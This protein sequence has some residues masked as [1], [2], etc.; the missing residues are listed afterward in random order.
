MYFKYKMLKYLTYAEPVLKKTKSYSYNSKVLVKTK[1]RMAPKIRKVN[2][3]VTD[4]ASLCGMDHYGNRNK[5]LCRIWKQL[6][7]G[8]YKE[9][10]EIIRQKGLSCALDSN[11][12]KIKIMEQRTGTSVNVSS[13]ILSINQKKEKDSGALVKNQSTVSNDINNCDKLTKQEKEKMISLMN[14]ATNVVF[15]CRNEGRGIDAFTRIT[16]KTIQDKQTKLVYEFATTKMTNGEIIQWNITGKYDGLTTDNE[17]VEIKNRQ[18]KLFNTIR[19]YEMC[20]LQMY[21][22]MLNCNVAYLVEVLGGKT[23][24]QVNVLQTGK[25]DNYYSLFIEHYLDEVKQLMLEIPYSN[26]EEKCKIMSG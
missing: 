26:I 24:N 18:R 7:P 2:I 9:T 1:E 13:K 6:H 4:L 21:L 12:K 8:D 5:S 17:I 16:G 19:D 11:F 23:D 3:P 10:E 22:Y 14:S 15:G 25:Q 20:Q